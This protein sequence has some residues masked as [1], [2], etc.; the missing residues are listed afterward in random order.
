MSLTL[1]GKKIGMT[2]VYD[3]ENRLVPVTVVQAGPCPVLQIKTVDGKDGYNAIQIGFGVDQKG[4]RVSK[5][6]QGHLKKAGVE[7]VTDICEFIPDGEEVTLGEA[8]TVN[9]FEEGQKID[10]IGTTKGRGFQGVM[11]RHGFAGNPASHG[12]MMRRRGGSY[13]MCQWPGEVIKG[14]KMPGHMGNARR[15][16][17]NLDIVRIIEDQNLILIRG[18]VHGP[19]GGT[20][21]IRKAIKTKKQK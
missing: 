3:G 21:F 16:T 12:S 6:L 7:A 20:V 18:S 1:I 15:T 14:K 11:K 2:Q 17:Q 4:H 8:L 10:I 19:K 9:R 5:P 13:G